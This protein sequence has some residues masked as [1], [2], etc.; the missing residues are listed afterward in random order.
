MNDPSAASPRVGAIESDAAA[1]DFAVPADAIRFGS[2]LFR[3]AFARAGRRSG[4]SYWLRGAVVSAPDG[5]F[6]RS[7]APL[8]IQK[9]ACSDSLLEAL[10]IEKSGFKGM[11]LLVADSLLTP[12]IRTSFAQTVRTSTEPYR[13]LD[14]SAYRTGYSDVLWMLVDAAGEW[15]AEE[16]QMKKMLRGLQ[17]MPKSFGTQPL[18]CC[19]STKLTQ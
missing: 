8:Y 18:H 10:S 9:C 6:M 16:L 19:S 15:E 13:R 11:C 5:A 12:T 14:H 1:F 4:P 2:V 17:M 7:T 3:T